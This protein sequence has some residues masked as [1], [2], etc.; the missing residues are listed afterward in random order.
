MDYYDQILANMKSQSEDPH[1]GW[2]DKQIKSEQF[3]A[4]S[5]YDVYAENVLKNTPKVLRQLKKEGNK[6]IKATLVAAVT[7]GLQL[8]S[9]LRDKNV[10][11]LSCREFAMQRIYQEIT[12]EED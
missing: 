11:A 7:S 5:E 6:A 8:F 12:G 3:I 10:N 4:M 2:Y 9:H 1:F